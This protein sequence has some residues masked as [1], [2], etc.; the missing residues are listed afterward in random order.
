MKADRLPSARDETEV[1][2]AREAARPRSTIRYR[3]VYVAD[4]LNTRIIILP[5]PMSD[6][7]EAVL[8]LLGEGVRYAS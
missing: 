4:P 6:K 5:N 8:H 7:A 3:I 1:R 2:N